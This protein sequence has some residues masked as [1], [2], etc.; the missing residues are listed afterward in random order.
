MSR[1]TFL[2]I[3]ILILLSIAAFAQNSKSPP[4]DW[5]ILD[6]EKDHLQGVSAERAYAELLQGRQARTIIVAVIDSGIDIDHEDLKSIIWTNEKEV[7]SNGID[8]DKN[9][10]VDD[11][12]GWNFIGGKDA[13]VNEDTYEITR[14]YVRLKQLFGGVDESTVPRKQKSEFQQYK[15]T[16]D[17]FEKRK[18]KEVKQYEMLLQQYRLYKN[19]EEN[20]VRSNDTLKLVLGK[21]KLT[22]TDSI[23][24]A[25]TNPPCCFQKGC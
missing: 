15:V 23:N 1:T 2:Y 7:P 17:K 12:H 11:I 22:P 16:K 20:L 13:N 5:Y 3:P 10:Y 14:E 25:Q 8:D 24:L 19:I 4:N 9:G 18:A 6:P 21:E